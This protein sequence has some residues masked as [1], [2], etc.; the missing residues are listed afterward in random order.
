MWEG[1]QEEEERT[2][3]KQENMWGAGDRYASYFDC[4]NDFMDIYTRTYVKTCQIVHFKC[5]IFYVNNTS[6][7]L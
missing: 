6:T 5:G 4:S 3:K 7:K 2:T 1:G